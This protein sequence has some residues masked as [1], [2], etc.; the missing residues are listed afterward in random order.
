MEYETT[1]KFVSESI[2][3]DNAGPSNFSFLIIS[4]KNS[5]FS[6]AGNVFYSI[7]IRNSFVYVEQRIIMVYLRGYLTVVVKTFYCK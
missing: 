1:A 2:K 7:K 5:N 3:Q 4:I 6:F